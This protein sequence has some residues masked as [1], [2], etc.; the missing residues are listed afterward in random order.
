LG[1]V[2]GHLGA[3]EGQASLLV[4][5]SVARSEAESAVVVDVAAHLPA[6]GGGG[7]VEAGPHLGA[8]RVGEAADVLFEDGGIL[9]AGLPARGDAVLQLSAALEVLAGVG[10]GRLGGAAE[11]EGG[12][13]Q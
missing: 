4:E 13:D 6:D 11:R 3:A 5:L 9:L 1:L 7:G 12:D 10:A 2:L 8:G